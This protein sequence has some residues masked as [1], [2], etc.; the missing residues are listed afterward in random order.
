[1]EIKEQRATFSIERKEAAAMLGVSM[2]TIDRYI[3]NGKIASKKVGFNVFLAKDELEQLMRKKA[4]RIAQVDVLPSRRQEE[5]VPVQ[6]SS[7]PVQYDAVRAQSQS[8]AH[9][10][11][12]SFDILV[13]QSLYE[14]TKQQLEDKQKEVEV[15]HY[16]L[17]KMEVEMNQMVPML[18]YRKDQEKKLD[19][20]T[21]VTQK[22]KETTHELK[23]TKRSNNR[24][25]QEKLFYIGSVLML[26]LLSTILAGSMFLP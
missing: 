9:G 2:R 12:P 18:E 22:L 5:E 3:R 4:H 17:G 6:Q 26:A 21:E 25:H 11:A 20:L 7:A 14:G 16:K 13:Y 8:Q 1:M 23:L 15:L 10:E 19:E 24:M